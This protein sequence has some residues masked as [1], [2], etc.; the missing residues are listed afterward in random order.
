MLELVFAPAEDWIGRPDEEIIAATM[1]E[2]ERLFPTEIAADQS[3][4][5]ILKYKVVK[6]PLSVYKATAGRE[7]YRWVARGRTQRTHFAFV[8]EASSMG[9]VSVSTCCKQD[10]AV[11]C[12]VMPGGHGCWQAGCWR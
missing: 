8:M 2:L 10:M 6:T 11:L 12:V 7:D 5:K 9:F 1:G 4:A 3:K